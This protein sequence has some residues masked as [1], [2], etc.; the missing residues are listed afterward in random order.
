[1]FQS[2]INELPRDFNILINTNLE[3]KMQ[4]LNIL[5]D[6]HTKGIYISLNKPVKNLK[7][8]LQKNNIKTD[9][10][11]FIDGIT[12]SLGSF[13][14][15]P[16]TE[17]VFNLKQIEKLEHAITTISKHIGLSEKFLILDSLPVLLNYHDKDTVLKFLR[18]LSSKM[19]D[20]RIKGIV[21]NDQSLTDDFKKELNL[22]FDKTIQL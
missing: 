7:D 17:Y 1:M 20:L 6:L 13:H 11:Y 8:Q 4:V 19:R 12:R 21:I 16:K 5:D 15:M 18:F 3:N 2:H 9:N 10:L 22:I 14:R